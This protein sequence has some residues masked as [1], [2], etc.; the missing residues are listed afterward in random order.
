MDIQEISSVDINVVAPR[1]PIPRPEAPA[2]NMR[3]SVAANDDEDMDG[4][5]KRCS[6]NGQCLHG[7]CVCAVETGFGGVDCSE[8][9]TLCP[10]LC[11]GN[12]WCDFKTGACE[13]SRGFSGS[14]CTVGECFA[15]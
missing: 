13:C 12:G 9:L 6:G 10:G 4:C 1:I 8:A 2:V 7:K 14:D 3:T 11:S 15:T 5:P